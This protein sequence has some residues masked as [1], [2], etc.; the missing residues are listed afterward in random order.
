[1]LKERGLSQ[2]LLDAKLVIVQGNA[3]DPEAARKVLIDDNSHVVDRVVFG[4]GGKPKFTLNPLKPATLDDPTVC[5]DSI[6]GINT[7]LRRIKS[8]G[9]ATKMPLLAALSTT[10]ISE[11]R[12]LPIMMM[13]LYRLLGAV[14]HADKK[15]LEERIIEA[16]REN[17]IRDF[18]IIRPSF[19]LNGQTNGKTDIKVGWEGKAPGELGEG[20][21]IGYTITRD[22]VGFFVFENV[23]ANDGGDF[24]G[25]KVSITH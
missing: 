8:S 25:R 9:Q 17:L 15:V 10:G 23:I 21:A 13:F 12:D 5:Q 22:D 3:K 20:A 18:V 4:I 14:P 2:S 11:S 6:L 24:L 19:L 7:A 1:M 16:K